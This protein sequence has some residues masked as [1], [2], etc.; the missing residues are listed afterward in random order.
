MRDDTAEQNDR[1]EIPASTSGRSQPGADRSTAQPPEGTL[2]DAPTPLAAIPHLADL[3][4]A[5]LSDE[6][7]AVYRQR[8]TEGFYSSPEVAAEVARR[9]LKH[10]DI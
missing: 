8:V 5:G 3:E 1:D 10:G 7:I 6:E 2:P 9:M 4:E